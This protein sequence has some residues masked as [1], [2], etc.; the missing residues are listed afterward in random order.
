MC[1][2]SESCVIRSNPTAEVFTGHPR[3]SSAQSGVQ[4]DESRSL[5]GRIE[6]RTIIRA[7]LPCNYK[8]ALASLRVLNVFARCVPSGPRQFARKRPDL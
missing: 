6:P 5:S 8:A 3:A 2:V 1:L 7:D 4:H